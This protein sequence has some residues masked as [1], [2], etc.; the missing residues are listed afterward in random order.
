MVDWIAMTPAERADNL[1]EALKEAI[2][3][4]D[5]VFADLENRI[6]ALEE[7]TARLVQIIAPKH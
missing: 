1:R 3:H 7:Q 6:M 5:A 4:Q 2:D